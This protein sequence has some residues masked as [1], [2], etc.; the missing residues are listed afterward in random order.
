M[1]S[2]DWERC[3]NYPP[4]RGAVPDETAPAVWVDLLVFIRERR[5]KGA[6]MQVEFDDVGGGKRLLRQGSEKELVDDACPR[7]AHRALLFAGGMG[8]DDHAA[9]DGLWPDRHIWA[10]VEAAGD[11]AFG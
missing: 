5:L 2:S 8:R 11:L 4:P 3:P 10:I 1:L 7:D 9:E 6:A